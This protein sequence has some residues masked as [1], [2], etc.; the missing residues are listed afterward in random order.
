MGELDGMAV[1]I[2]ERQ[3]PRHAEGS[4]RPVRRAAGQQVLAQPRERL[5]IGYVER[6][7]VNPP[8]RRR[9]RSARDGPVP[10]GVHRELDQRPCAKRLF[11]EGRQPVKVMGQ[12]GDVVDAV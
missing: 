7:V 4:D 11:I 5:R 1:R 10:L 6:E 9:L 3:Y 8:R 2:Y 12:E